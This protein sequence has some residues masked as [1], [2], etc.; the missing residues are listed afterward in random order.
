MLIFFLMPFTGVKRLRKPHEPERLEMETGCG[1][2]VGFHEISADTF[3]SSVE[4]GETGLPRSVKTLSVT[5]GQR[6]G[7]WKLAGAVFSSLSTKFP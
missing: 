5:G 2:F 3:G 1:V 4:S 7:V 6:R